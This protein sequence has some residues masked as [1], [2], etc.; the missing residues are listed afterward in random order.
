MSDSIQSSIK[1][2]MNSFQI[3]IENELIQLNET[4]KHPLM[5]LKQQE[6]KMVL[7]VNDSIEQLIKEITFLSSSCSMGIPKN[8]IQIQPFHSIGCEQE[9]DK[10]IQNC[11]EQ[12]TLMR[13]INQN[14]YDAYKKM[15]NIISKRETCE[16]LM[17]SYINHTQ[18]MQ[19]WLISKN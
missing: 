1:N 11:L 14:I 4:L 8:Q 6:L 2:L 7:N 10:F 19:N 17:Q 16:K 12:L 18:S 3:Q 15:Q 9:I 5:E 13:V